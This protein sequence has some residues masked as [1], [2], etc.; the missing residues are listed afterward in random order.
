MLIARNS[1]DGRAEV[2]CGK[3][4]ADR[5]FASMLWIARHPTAA[6]IVLLRVDFEQPRAHTK[7]IERHFS[8]SILRLFYRPRDIP[9]RNR[10]LRL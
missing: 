9:K 3:T 7:V 1:F 10:V 5:V 8:C 4:P 6:P 2:L